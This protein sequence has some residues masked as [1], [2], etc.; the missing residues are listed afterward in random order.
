VRLHPTDVEVDADQRRSRG[1]T[2]QRDYD[3]EAKTY[4]R[5]LSPII[6]RPDSAYQRYEPVMHGARRG[7]S[8]SQ[9][10]PSPSHRYVEAP[11]HYRFYPRSSE[12]DIPSGFVER[13]PI[14]DHVHDANVPLRRKS[15]KIADRFFVNDREE[16]VDSRRRG[17]SRGRQENKV[18]SRM[19]SFDDEHESLNSS[20]SF[21]S[22]SQQRQ[23]ERQTEHIVRHRRES[24][25]CQPTE[26]VV[27]RETTYPSRT[28][29]RRRVAWRC[30]TS[31]ATSSHPL[32]RTQ[33]F[34]AQQ[35]AASYYNDDWESH[36][37][38]RPAPRRTS[39]G[40]R[41]DRYQ[42]SELGPSEASYGHREGMF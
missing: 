32:D 20:R 13:E 27:T 40:F 35:D 36:T 21:G 34:P 15:Q 16:S 1:R 38:T 14:Y 17:F 3:E 29:S 24:Q 33:T 6:N 28:R 22:S 4:D 26:R 25:R 39:T 11:A 2:R 37:T 7:E 42:D 18:P 8:S 23:R 19:P 5:A 9:R 30:E 31:S 12:E 10:S 41:R